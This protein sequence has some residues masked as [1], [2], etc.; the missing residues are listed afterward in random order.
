MRA[1]VRPLAGRRT[2]L[3]L[4]GCLALAACAPERAA[5]P[6]PEPTP[7]FDLRPLAYEQLA[8]WDADDP[9]EA[10]GAFARSCAK[11]E[12]Y[13]AATPMGT[14][15]WFGAVGDWRA[16]CADAATAVQNSAAQGSTAEG[17][18][19]E[20]RD[21][22]EGHFSPYLVIDGDDPEGLFTGYYEPLLFGSRRFGGPYTVPIYRPPDDLVRVDLGRFNPDL[23]GYAIYGRIQGGQF[24]PYYARADIETGALAGRDLELLWVDDPI[25]KFFLQIQGSGQVRLDDGS[26]VRVGYAS[27]N[28]HPYHAIGRDLIEMEV[29]GREEVS[30][31]AIKSWLEA[32]PGD[33]PQ[34]M[35]R[36][37]S[38]IFFE[39][40]P[41]LGPEDGP[42]GS[43]GVSLTAGRSL[44]VDRRYIPLGVPVWL[45]TVA[46][47]PEG[48][49]PLRR[50]MVAQDTGGAIK[51]VVRGDVF[52][53]AG[54]RAESIAGHMRSPGR[55]AVLLPKALIPTS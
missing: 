26:L 3:L 31:P 51:G 46:P 10:L 41:E 15:P 35:A 39:E 50:L 32:H 1:V 52:W 48:E 4:G 22:F 49:G 25:D 14:S 7:V 34:I 43:Q 8:G 17:S 6:A 38:Y 33:A 20:V 36:N 47:W 9:R 2:C 40:R 19:A 13:D 16:A 53:G 29:L 30:L 55:Y 21:F 42:L 11:L 24:V 45:D 54:A 28:G 12:Q 23:A 27:Q 18:A 5:P 37:R 44:A